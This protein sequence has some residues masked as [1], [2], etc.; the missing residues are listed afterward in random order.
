[1]TRPYLLPALCALLLA[2]SLVHADNW[3][4]WR[5]PTFDGISA[6]TGLNKDWAAKTPPTLW[7][8]AMYDGG[9]S[10]PAI[11]DGVVYIID[12]KGPNDVLRALDATTGKSL[13]ETGYPDGGAD[14]REGQARSV[15]TVDS[16]KVYT[17][18]KGG[19]ATCFNAADGKIVW[20]HYL[21]N[22]LG[23]QF[24]DFGYSSSPLVDGKQVVF[25]PGGNNGAGVVALDKETG[26]LIWKANNYGN[27]GYGTPMIF[28]FDGKKQYLVFFGSGVSSVDPATGAE[29]WRYK[30]VTS[31]SCNGV[32]LAPVGN[33][34]FIGISGYGHGTEMVQVQDNAPTQMWKNSFATKICSPVVLKDL[35]FCLGEN[36][37]LC[38][39]DV[40]TGKTMWTQGGFSAGNWCSGLIAADGVLIVMNHLDG[41]IVL[42]EPTANGYHEL[43]RLLA[44]KGTS[45]VAPA[46]SNKKLYVRTGRDLYCVDL[47]PDAKPAEPVAP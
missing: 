28:N 35:V 8:V 44:V 43:G 17:W 15:P 37:N 27:P 36:A 7:N 26:E 5:G 46:L 18:S 41:A 1:M 20:Q 2:A 25:V 31:E 42:V 33:N 40:K 47:S 13:W 4:N 6:E 38:C 29:N 34:A 11:V 14:A 21:K 10:G 30:W 23:G 9:Y 32:G 45:V 3:A 24:P 12:H 19:K 22:E 39:M 16:G